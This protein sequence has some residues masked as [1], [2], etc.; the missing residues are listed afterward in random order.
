[1]VFYDLL[2]ISGMQIKIFY[3][4]GQTFKTVRFEDSITVQVL[5][6]SAIPPSLIIMTVV[7]V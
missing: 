5:F 6:L 1:M 3:D 2:L 7:L 4:H